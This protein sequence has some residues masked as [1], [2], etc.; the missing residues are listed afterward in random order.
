MD[1]LVPKKYKE[2]WISKLSNKVLGLFGDYESEDWKGCIV[3]GPNGIG[4]TFIVCAF[5]R[6]FFG[7]RI[8]RPAV[9]IQSADL[10]YL[11]FETDEFRGQPWRTTLCNC[12]CLII[13]DLGKEDRRNDKTSALVLQR[14][15][16]VLRWRVQEERLTMITT[17]LSGEELEKAYGSS[18]Y[19][20]LHELATAWVE[21]NGP[22]RRRQVT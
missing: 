12:E 14:L 18:I 6:Y 5:A 8:R 17:N 13:D 10:P 4:K 2:A 16:T 9:F 22:D 20:L 11:W 19:S 15:G 7:H 21:L 3:E 1:G